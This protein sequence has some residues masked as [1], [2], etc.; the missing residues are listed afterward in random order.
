V[1]PA[2]TK[3]QSFIRLN[4]GQYEIALNEKVIP[5]YGDV[6]STRLLHVIKTKTTTLH[7]PLME[8]YSQETNLTPTPLEIEA[9]LHCLFAEN[10]KII[11]TA[12]CYRKCGFDDDDFVPERH[13]YCDYKVLIEEDLRDIDWLYEKFLPGSECDTYEEVPF[14]LNGMPFQEFEDISLEPPMLK[15]SRPPGF[16]SPVTLDGELV[17]ELYFR[18]KCLCLN[19]NKREV[20]KKVEFDDDTGYKK[21]ANVYI[22]NNIWK[23][24]FVL[25]LE[26]YE[27]NKGTQ[28]DERSQRLRST[29]EKCKAPAEVVRKKE[30]NTLLESLENAIPSQEELEKMVDGYLDI[31]GS[32]WM[33]PEHQPLLKTHIVR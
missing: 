23:K 28:Q 19:S 20:V 21:R 2:I 6:V 32:F 30:Q 17:K 10:V 7:E 25:N 12:S 18:E 9:G 1:P 27:A 29:Y 3:L 13:F 15:D 31:L 11:D 26:V 8:L 24:I 5:R 16:S 22:R 4:K 33:K 14:L